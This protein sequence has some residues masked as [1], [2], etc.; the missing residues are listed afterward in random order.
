MRPL[1]GSADAKRARGGALSQEIIR[2][3]GKRISVFA[4]RMITNSPGPAA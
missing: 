1:S 3:N 4:S 2:F